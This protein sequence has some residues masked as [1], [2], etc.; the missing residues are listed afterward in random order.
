MK[1]IS[2]LV[3]VFASLAL[4]STSVESVKAKESIVPITL[5]ST[6]ELDSNHLIRTVLVYSGLAFTET[7][8]KKDSESQ[9]KLFKEI[10]KSGF[11]Q[12]SIPMISDTAKNVQYISTDEAVLSYIILSYNKE[13]LSKNLLLHTVS[14]QLSSIARSY[15]KKTTKI[16]DSSK[17][18][19]CSKLLTNENIHQTLKVLNDTFT[20]TEHKFLMGK[21]VSFNDLITYNLILF[22]ENVSSGCVISNFKGLRE[23]ALNVSSIPQIFKFESS[24]YFMS[25]LVPGTHAFAKRINFA[26]SSAIFLSLA[27]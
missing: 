20:S 1:S 9:A 23:L 24:S 3:S 17:T 19:T 21:K 26:H 11:L 27:S 14:I 5:Y 12:P 4:F 10:T 6:K 16:L 22:I 8:F 25:L 18:L 2:L 7:R 15:I 13:L